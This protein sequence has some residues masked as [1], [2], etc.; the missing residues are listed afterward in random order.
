MTGDGD[1]SKLD[2]S[3]PRPVSILRTVLIISSRLEESFQ[4]RVVQVDVVHVVLHG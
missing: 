4:R 3:S 1:P 2:W